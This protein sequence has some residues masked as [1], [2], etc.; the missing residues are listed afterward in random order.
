MFGD[1]VLSDVRVLAVDQQLVE[2]ASADQPIPKASR[3]VTVEVAPDQVARLAVA[4]RLGKLAFAVRPALD[5]KATPTPGP[6]TVWAGDVAPGLVSDVPPPPTR[7]V[8][9][10]WQGT[11]DSKE[12]QF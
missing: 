6:A 8:M 11:A 2:G 1:T 12:F 3:T 4:I 5:A 9:H 10:V 7:R